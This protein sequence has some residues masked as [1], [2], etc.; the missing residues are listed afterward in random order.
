MPRQLLQTFLWLGSW[1]FR[2]FCASCVLWWCQRCPSL[3]E[4]DSRQ[5]FSSDNRSGRASDW[6]WKE[7]GVEVRKLCRDADRWWLTWMNFVLCF[8]FCTF[9]P[10]D[11]TVK[12]FTAGFLL[13]FSSLSA[14]L[15]VSGRWGS[16]QLHISFALWTYLTQESKKFSVLQLDPYGK[17]CDQKARRQSLN[18]SLNAS[19]EVYKEISKQWAILMVKSLMQVK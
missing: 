16:R 7:T 17:R 18:K 3:R 8:Y 14:A 1:S 11:L 12:C 10:S 4:S 13:L 19:A 9:V 2:V 6:K 15:R 5:K